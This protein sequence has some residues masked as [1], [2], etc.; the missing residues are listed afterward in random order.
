MNSEFCY[1]VPLQARPLLDCL[2][3]MSAEAYQRH[4]SLF[5]SGAADLMAPALI[6]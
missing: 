6:D 4:H 3:Q 2:D 1:G 5:K